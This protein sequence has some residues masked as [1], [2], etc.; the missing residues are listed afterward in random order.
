MKGLFAERAY[1]SVLKRFWGLVGFLSLL[2]VVD[3][4][5]FSLIGSFMGNAPT[6]QSHSLPME[7]RLA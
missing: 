5:S 4:F 6:F 1:N 3:F 2:V 7:R